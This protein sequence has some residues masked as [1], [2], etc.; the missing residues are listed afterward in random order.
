MVGDN[1]PLILKR[2]PGLVLLAFLGRTVHQ[3]VVESIIDSLVGLEAAGIADIGGHLHQGLDLGDPHHDG[4][5]G[6][7]RPDLVRLE[8]S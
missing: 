5:D 2:V 6:D 1:L 7:Q 8:G 4:L 3:R